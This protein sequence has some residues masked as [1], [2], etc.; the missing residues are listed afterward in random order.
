MITLQPQGTKLIVKPI[1]MDKFVTES[2]IEIPNLDMEM[3]EVME[4]SEEHK[5]IYQKWDKVLY[6]KGAGMGISY[7]KSICLILDGT[8]SPKGDVIA[9]VKDDK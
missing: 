3:G 7:K 9:I 5:D 6:S 1:P 8:G 4:V 2:D